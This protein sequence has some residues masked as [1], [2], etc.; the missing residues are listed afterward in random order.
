MK[1]L[2]CHKCDKLLG[3]ADGTDY[4]ILLHCRKC[5]KLWFFYG[6]DNN[7]VA[8]KDKIKIRVPESAG[9]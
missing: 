7:I 9:E 2:R 4:K 5:K 6:K 1:E 8:T 3:K